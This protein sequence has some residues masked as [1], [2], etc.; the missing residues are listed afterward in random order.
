ML[1][2][3]F[4]EICQNIWS[5]NHSSPSKV[6]EYIIYLL[7]L[8]Y[9][10][11]VMHIFTTLL[12]SCILHLFKLLLLRKVATLSGGPE[13]PH[14]FTWDKKLENRALQRL[15]KSAQFEP[16]RC[17]LFTP[18]FVSHSMHSVSET[19]DRATWIRQQTNTERALPCFLFNLN[20]GRPT[21]KLV[22]THCCNLTC[23]D[24]NCK[25]LPPLTRVVHPCLL[26]DQST[27]LSPFSVVLQRRVLSTNAQKHK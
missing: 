16:K 5:K 26:Q 27:R 21:T 3:T 4:C 11:C 18:N 22:W 15:F 10:V 23:V 17:F 25:P 6:L 19:P 8:F 14:Q 9:C 13:T 2:N 7:F 20:I 24:C 1:C 12:F